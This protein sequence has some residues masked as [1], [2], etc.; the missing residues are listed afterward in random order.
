MGLMGLMGLMGEIG[1]MGVMGI[2][3]VTG[4]REV[5]VCARASTGGVLYKPE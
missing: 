3:E 5:T 4:L 2:M 1:E